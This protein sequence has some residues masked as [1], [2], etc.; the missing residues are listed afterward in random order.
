M[1]PGGTIRRER[2]VLDQQATRLSSLF[3]SGN[4]PNMLEKTRGFPSLPHD[5][6][7]FF[8]ILEEMYYFLQDCQAKIQG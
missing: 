3:V 5:R 2:I 6:F 8:S 4:C 7:G 1:R